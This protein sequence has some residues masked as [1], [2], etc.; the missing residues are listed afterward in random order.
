[1]S[2]RFS[3][4]LLCCIALLVGCTLYILLRPTTHIGELFD[5]FTLITNLRNALALYPCDFLKYYLPD[6]LWGFSLCCGLIAIFEPKT[7]GL[8]GCAIVAFIC[9]ASWETLQFYN[10]TTGVGDYKDIVMYLL[11]VIISVT[12]NIKRGYYNEKNN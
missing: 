4:M 7:K 11:A 6:F 1:M 5:K 8:I 12:I 10:I 9:G 3:N 2:K